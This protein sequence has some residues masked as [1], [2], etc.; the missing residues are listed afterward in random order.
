MPAGAAQAAAGTAGAPAK[1]KAAP[2][3]R[4]K[5]S[6]LDAAQVE[7]KVRQMCAQGLQEKLSIPEIKCFLKARKVAVGGKKADLLSRL[8]GVLKSAPA[9]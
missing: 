6:D 7:A 5:A 3:A 2:R 4:Q 9:S 1:P 8:S